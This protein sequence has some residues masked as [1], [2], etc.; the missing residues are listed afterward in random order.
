MT[1][2]ERTQPTD[3]LVYQSLDG[4]V[5]DD[6]GVDLFNI[7]SETAVLSLGLTGGMDTQTQVVEAVSDPIDAL[8]QYPTRI[9]VTLV[10]VAGQNFNTLFTPEVLPMP[11]PQRIN[12]EA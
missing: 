6:D 12:L 1:G 11:I 9:C 7:N 2:A 8:K 5:I 3:D 4:F 10:P